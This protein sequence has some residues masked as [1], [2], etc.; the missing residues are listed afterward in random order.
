[1]NVWGFGIGDLWERLHDQSALLQGLPAALPG[2]KEEM[3]RLLAKVG[4]WCREMDEL[5][6]LVNEGEL[7]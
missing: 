4:H 2:F 1:M 5:W 6:D 3:D 7:V